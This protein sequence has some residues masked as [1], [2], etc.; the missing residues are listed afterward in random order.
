[1]LTT[2]PSELILAIADHLPPHHVNSLV[3]TCSGFQALPNTYLYRRVAR[4]SL[5]S[6]KAFLWALNHSNV[7]TMQSLFDHG[8]RLAKF[9]RSEWSVN[10]WLGLYYRSSP[11]L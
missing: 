4:D 2:L 8:A 1:M 10:M 11:I 7:Q 5:A 9:N 6:R 3:R